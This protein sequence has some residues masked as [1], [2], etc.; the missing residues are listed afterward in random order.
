MEFK[1]Q[2]H[3]FLANHE[4]SSLFFSLTEDSGFQALLSGNQG[5][6]MSLDLV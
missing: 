5:F 3:L 2:K 6:G 1:A 4:F